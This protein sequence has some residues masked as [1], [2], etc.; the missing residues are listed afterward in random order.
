M[1]QWICSSNSS[2]I[3]NNASADMFCPTCPPFSGVL[4]EF[5]GIISTPNNIKDNIGLYIFLLDSSGSMFNEQAF[6]NVQMSRAQLVSGQVANAIFEMSQLSNQEDA[7]LFVLLFDHRLKSFVN[8]LSVQE[9]FLKYSTVEDLQKALLNEMQELA[10]AT[11]INLALS[12][13]YKHAQEFIDGKMEIIGEVRPMAATLL[14]MN[15]DS[16]EFPNIRCLIFTDGEQF[17]G[18]NNDNR[19]I[20]NPFKDFKFKGNNV[21]VLMGAFHGEESSDGYRQLKEILGTCYKHNEKQFF[22]FSHASQVMNMRNL[23]RMA[24]GP[25]GFCEKCLND[26]MNS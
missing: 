12:T 3:F 26:L 23:F 13:A 1:A 8:F 10:G 4:M 21:D 22:H 7:Y 2:H 18:H 14:N 15:G 16:R 24:S 9:I 6:D 5:D 25:G 11:D 19:I 17:T 20:K